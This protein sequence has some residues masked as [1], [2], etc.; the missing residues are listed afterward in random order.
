LTVAS[1]A[2]YRERQWFRTETRVSFSASIAGIDENG[3]VTFI[4]KMI[5][6]SSRSPRVACELATVTG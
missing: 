6:L 5:L 1:T 2:V 4:G 3:P